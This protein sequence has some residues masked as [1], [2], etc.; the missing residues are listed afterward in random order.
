LP[1]RPPLCRPSPAKKKRFA[2]FAAA[3]LEAARLRKPF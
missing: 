2:G 1:G 3:K